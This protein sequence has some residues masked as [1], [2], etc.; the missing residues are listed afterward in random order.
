MSH[1]VVVDWYDEDHPVAVLHSEREAQEWVQKAWEHEASADPL[2]RA[3]D[4]YGIVE[5]R[6][7]EP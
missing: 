2:G 1:W 3:D 5:V 6:E 7:V 4:H